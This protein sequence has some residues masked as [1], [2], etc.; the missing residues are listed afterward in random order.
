MQHIDKLS[1]NFL[2]PRGN[3]PLGLGLVYET[4]M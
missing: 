4:L 2:I 3:T 1:L